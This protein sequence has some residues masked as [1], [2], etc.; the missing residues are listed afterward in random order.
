MAII[1][2]ND[3]YTIQREY[4]K[5]F[6]E[7]IFCTT[8]EIVHAAWLLKD[9]IQADDG[10]Y[11]FGKLVAEPLQKCLSIIAFT[12]VNPGS[13]TLLMPFIV[14]DHPVPTL[15]VSRNEDQKEGYYFHFTK[16]PFTREILIKIFQ[17]VVPSKG[18]SEIRQKLLDFL[19]DY[20][21]LE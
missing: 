9:Y 20:L 11:G 14:F 2:V 7:G 18:L 17:D 13:V 12:N 8:G 1:I 16:Q 5:S 4:N 3:E 19:C 6:E 21:P 15:F 10:G